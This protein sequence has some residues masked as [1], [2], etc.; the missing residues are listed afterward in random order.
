MLTNISTLN[1]QLL[2]LD[3][4]ERLFLTNLEGV[5]V[6]IKDNKLRYEIDAEKVEDI[7]NI[8]FQNLKIEVEEEIMNDRDLLFKKF[9]KLTFNK[10]PFKVDYLIET[11]LILQHAFGKENIGWIYLYNNDYFK[12]QL[13]YL[14]PR[15]IKNEDIIIKK[16]LEKNKIYLKNSTSEYVWKIIEDLELIFM[17]DFVDLTAENIL[18]LQKGHAIDRNH[19]LQD[20]KILVKEKGERDSSVWSLK[21]LY[22][23]LN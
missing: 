6:V 1:K 17:V 11:I 21:K 22:D 13:K 12:N 23:H 18:K 3:D 14:F 4:K 9:K 2:K 10:Y 7:V 16:V 20:I 5:T 15:N 19:T 8:D